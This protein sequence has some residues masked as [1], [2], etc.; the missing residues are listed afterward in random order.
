M[1]SM[2]YILIVLYCSVDSLRCLTGLDKLKTL[3][4]CD[5]IQELSNPVCLH[6]NYM[7][8]MIALF[9]NLE[10]LDGMY[11]VREFEIYIYI[12]NIYF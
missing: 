3:R 4:L 2:N 10:W 9:P 1:A 5:K 12:L 7:S 8:D 11:I 6:Q